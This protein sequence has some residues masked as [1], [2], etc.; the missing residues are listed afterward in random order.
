MTQDYWENLYQQVSADVIYFA[1]YT[2]DAVSI[3][4]GQ[5]TCDLQVAGSSP[6][7]APLPSGLGPG[8]YTCVPVSPSGIIWYWP[9]G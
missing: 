4:A 7:W 9:R 3:L 6:G 1:I 5:R 8:T 2:G